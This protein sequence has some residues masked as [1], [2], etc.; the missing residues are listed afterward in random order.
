M[1]R[2]YHLRVEQA[3]IPTL[4]DLRNVHICFFWL[5]FLFLLNLFGQGVEPFEIKGNTHE[6]P[7]A[8]H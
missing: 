8:F 2:S 3:A 5:F 7:F 6:I 4:K 1:T